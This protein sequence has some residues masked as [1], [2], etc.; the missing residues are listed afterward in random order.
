MFNVRGINVFPT[1]VHSA[2]TTRPDL[3]SGQFRVRLRGPGPYDRVEL[4]AE[5]A[6]RLPE[7]AWADASRALE[8]AI[9][10]RLGASA[11]VTLVPFESLPRTAGKTGWVERVGP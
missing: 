1:A 6:A 9:R 8:S 4:A 10:A 3:C 5:A 2:L 7:P 11:R